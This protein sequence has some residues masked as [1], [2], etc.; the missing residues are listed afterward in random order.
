MK[1]QQNH[2]IILAST[3]P[4]R[5]ELIASLRLPF[6]VVPSHADEDT[7]VDY[8]P[9]QIVE[10]L[11]V[12]KAKAVF[13]SYDSSMEGAIVV[14]SDTIVV[15]NGMVLGKPKDEEDAFRMLD[16]LQNRTH[17]VYSGVAC[18]SGDTG[19]II[20]NH[21]KT[22]VKMKAQTREAILAYIGTGEP[23]DKAGAYAIQGIGSILVESIEGCYF[24]VVGLPLSLLSE[25][26]A[27]LGMYVLAID[28]K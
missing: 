11:S 2:R 21:R 20:V 18:I 7:P 22:K 25:Q 27:E 6:E 4:R 15:M 9:E 17:E 1:K 24:N 26:L 13:D 3:S 8:T 16:M 10:E 19:R 28:E 14:G 12:R 5:R 23:A